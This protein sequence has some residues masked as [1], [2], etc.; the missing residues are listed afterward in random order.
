MLGAII[1]DICGSPYEF[2]EYEVPYNFPLFVRGCTPTDDTVMTIAVADT[3]ID[4]SY[5]DKLSD[6][7]QFKDALIFKLQDYG[8]KYRNAGYGGSF[9]KWL[10]NPKPEPYGSFGNGSAMRVSPVGWVFDDIDTTRK[11]ARWTAEVTHNHPEGVKAAECVASVIFMARNNADM[12]QIS[13]YVNAEFGYDI[14]DIPNKNFVS[15]QTSIP[16]CLKSLYQ[17][18][19]FVD[20]IRTAISYGNDTDTY[21]AIT[22]SMAEAYYGLDEELIIKTLEYLPDEFHDI[23]NAFLKIR[24]EPKDGF[25]DL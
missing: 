23:M 11:V 12:I 10:W 13:E 19:N 8:R 24:K 3:L 2:I 21:G 17:S 5:R 1:G 15:C 6:E 9:I 20:A 14:N 4:C 16:I 18:H 25:Y 22:G 7:K